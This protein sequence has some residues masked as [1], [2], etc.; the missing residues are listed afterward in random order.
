MASDATPAAAPQAH[1]TSIYGPFAQQLSRVMDRIVEQ[2]ETF[3]A[4]QRSTT[5]EGAY[6]HF[7][8]RIKSEASMSITRGSSNAS[9]GL[10]NRIIPARKAS[11]SAW[12][13][14][15]N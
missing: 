10:T 5:G 8:H 1:G 7:S 13:W 6:E 3:D 4:E 2:I 11:A 14:R 12:R 9:T 15:A